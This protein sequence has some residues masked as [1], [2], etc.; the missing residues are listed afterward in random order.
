MAEEK[1]VISLEEF[2]SLFKVTEAPENIADFGI[3][4][5]EECL[6]PIGPN[7]P[8]GVADLAPFQP[9]KT[10]NTQPRGHRFEFKGQ[11]QRKPQRNAKNVKAKPVFAPVEVAP[12]FADKQ[13]ATWCTVK[14]DTPSQPAPT[15]Q[16]QQ[17]EFSSLTAAW[18]NDASKKP[19]QHTKPANTSNNF[20]W[21]KPANKPKTAFA[22]LL[23]KESNAPAANAAW[24]NTKQTNSQKSKSTLNDDKEWP[25]LSNL[26]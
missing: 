18:T 14:S 6:Q 3:F 12:A 19:Q 13:I 8:E 20:T 1:V 7:K 23:A 9:H 24:G 4:G 5:S 21:G 22:D 17:V 25:T 2:Y 16:P 15:Q 11:Q 26:K 10:E